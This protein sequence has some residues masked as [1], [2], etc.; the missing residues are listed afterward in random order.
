M[1]EHEEGRPL[2]SSLVQ[3]KNKGQGDEFYKLC[4]E[5]GMGNWRD[6]KNDPEFLTEQRNLCYEFWSDESN[7]EKFL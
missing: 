7:Y 5:L 4:E 2:L 6:L 1:D 3:T